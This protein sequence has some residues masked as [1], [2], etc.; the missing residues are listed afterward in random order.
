MHERVDDVPGGEEK[1]HERLPA[2]ERDVRDVQG[3]RAYS[4]PESTGERSSIVS[5][6]LSNGSDV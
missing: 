4:F 2:R 1:I 5:V 3:R 6:N